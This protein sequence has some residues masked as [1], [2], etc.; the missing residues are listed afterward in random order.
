[1]I[2]AVALVSKVLEVVLDPRASCPWMLLVVVVVSDVLV[3]RVAK[4]VSGG[5]KF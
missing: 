4:M 2:T 5:N 1:M 3:V